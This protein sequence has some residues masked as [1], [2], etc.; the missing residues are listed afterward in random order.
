MAK[1]LGIGVTAWSPLAGGVLSGK[2]QGGSQAKDSRYSSD[3]MKAWQATGDRA[4]QIV[5]AVKQVSQQTGRSPAQIALAWLL[6]RDHLATVATVAWGKDGPGASTLSDLLDH[7][8]KTIAC[9]VESTS[10]Y[11]FLSAKN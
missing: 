1:A 9:P 4:D 7:D 11:T 2:Y 10:G 3:M 8:L 5:A 6:H